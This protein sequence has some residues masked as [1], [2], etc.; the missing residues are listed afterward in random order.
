M[1]TENLQLPV[2]NLTHRPVSAM[3]VD[4]AIGAGGLGLIP[5]PV[6]SDTVSPALRCFFGA[7]LPRC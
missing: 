7:V 5:G 3:V 1:A 6:K 2:D 4:F